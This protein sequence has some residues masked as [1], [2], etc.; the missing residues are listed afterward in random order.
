[1]VHKKISVCGYCMLHRHKTF[2]EVVSN[3]R[4][5]LNLKDLKIYAYSF[6]D[7]FSP[8][9]K[10]QLESQINNFKLK[11]IPN[12]IPSHISEKD[13]YYN[14]KNI[15]YVRKSFPKSR[16]N[17]LHMNQYMSD[18]S[19]IQDILKYDLV[20]QFDDDS[21]FHKN[22]QISLDS[23]FNDKYKEIFTGNTFCYP[24]EKAIKTTVQLFNT[25]KIICKKYDITPKNELL[26]T[27]IAENDEK[28]FHKLRFSSGNFNIY[29]T[30][31]FTSQSWYKYILHIKEAGG[32][33]KHRWGD[34]E[35]IGIYGFLFYE[36]P[37]KDLNLL[38][39]GVYEHKPSFLIEDGGLIYTGPRLKSRVKKFLHNVV[40]FQKK[41]LKK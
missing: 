37:L 29:K 30:T 27:A 6:R 7:S 21:W 36:D 32:I 13:I 8:K 25:V 20:I 19:L 16:V 26:R 18:P 41:F 17:F 38:D 9:I 35:I 31:F 24:Y 5:N 39:G 3:I 23:L 14:K 33:F 34:C 2:S 4:T 11:Y 12:I 22:P 10:K 15:D 40:F 28:L 1:M